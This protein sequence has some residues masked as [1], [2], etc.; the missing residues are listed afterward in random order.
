M[1]RYASGK[2]TQITSGIRAILSNP[3]VYSC[4]QSLMGAHNSRRSFVSKYVKPFPGMKILD[5]GCGP[6]DILAYMEDVQY[7]GIDIDEAYIEQAKKKFG[8][9]GTFCCAELTLDKVEELPKFDVVLASGL[10]HH[11]DDLTATVLLKLASRALLRPDGRLITIDP[12]LDPSQNFISEFLVRHDRGQN[13]RTK[14]AYEKLVENL[15]SSSRATVSHIAWVPYTHCIM[16]C[17]V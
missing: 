16:E 10:L 7:W 15:F 1:C 14:P 4:F 5:I 8:A 13:V 6:A 12:C 2:M 17:V 3:V 9:R 11:L